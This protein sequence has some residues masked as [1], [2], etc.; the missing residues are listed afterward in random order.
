MKDSWVK[1]AGG[2][3]PSAD[4]RLRIKRMSVESN[5]RK[6]GRKM[7]VEEVFYGGRRGQFPVQA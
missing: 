3:R 6:R 5:G 4:K 7:T 2:R 1:W